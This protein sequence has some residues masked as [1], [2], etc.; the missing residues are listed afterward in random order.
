M[1]SFRIILIIA[2]FAAVASLSAADMTFLE[3][4]QKTVSPKT[5]VHAAASQYKPSDGESKALNEAMDRVRERKDI[6]AAIRT[7]AAKYPKSPNVE[8][9]AYTAIEQ[10]YYSGKKDDLEKRC[11]DYFKKYPTGLHSERVLDYYRWAKDLYLEVYSHSSFT[12]DTDASVYLNM[13]N[14]GAVTLEVHAV[15]GNAI[16]VPLR[17]IDP[18]AFPLNANTKV[19]EVTQ[20][21]KQNGPWGEKRTFYGSVTLGK[22]KP[23]LY[24]VLAKTKEMQSATIISVSRLGVISKSDMGKSVLFVMDKITGEPVRDAS[25]KAYY[26]DALVATGSSDADGIAVLAKNPKYSGSFS[27]TVRRENDIAFID[28]YHGYGQQKTYKTYFYTDRPVYR[29]AQSVNYKIILREKAEGLSYSVPAESSFKVVIETPT[30]KKVYEKAVTANEYGAIADS[31]ELAERAELGWYRFRVLDKHGSQ[32]TDQFYTYWMPETVK[33]F[34][35]EEYKKPEFKMTVSPEKPS[36]MKGDDVTMNVDVKYYFGE[37]VKKGVVEYRITYAQHSVPYWYYYP[38]AWYYSEDY[39]YD[40][41]DDRP[42]RGRGRYRRNYEEVLVEGKAE[43]DEKGI[44]RIKFTAKDIPYDAKYTVSVR[45][46]DSSRRMIEGAASVKVAQAEFAATLRSDKYVYRPNDAALITFSGK[47]I[48]GRAF[49]FAGEL[50]IERYDWNN[51]SEKR[52]KVSVQEV[53]TE[54][55]GSGVFTFVP[56]REGNYYLT[57][58]A[59]DSRGRVVSARHSVYVAGYSYQSFYNYSSLTIVPNK[60]QYDIGDTA[61]MMIQSPYPS[62]YAIVSC[63]SERLLSYKVVKMNGSVAVLDCPLTE[64][65]APNFYYTVT[66]VRQNQMNTQTKPII[67]LPRKRFLT[68]AIKPNKASYRPGET[69]MFDLTVTD[70]HKNPVACDLSF[71]LVDASLYYIQEEFAKDPREFFYGKTQLRVSTGN[72]FHVYFHGKRRSAQAALGAAA[73][74][75][76]A[77][78]EMRSESMSKSASEKSKKD[79]GDRDDAAG[80]EKEP[81]VRGYFPDTAFW[82]HSIRTG[83]DGKATIT[84]KMPDTLTAW[85]ATVRAV[86]LA[87]GVGSERGETVTF[88]NLLCRLELPRFI[89]QDDVLTI[90]GIVHNYLKSEKSV[91]AELTAAGVNMAASNSMRDKLPSGVDKRFD[92]KVIADKPGRAEFTLKALTDE[93]SDAMKLSI[94]ILAHG[95]PR[96]VISSEVLTGGGITRTVD[97]PA[98]AIR[99]TAE[100]AVNASGSIAAAMFASLD[101]LIGYPYGCVEQ[102]MSRFLPNV[103]VAQSVKRLKLP[104]PEIFKKLPD[105]MDKGLTRLY[106]LQHS[107]GG[108]GWWNNDETH[109][110]MTAYVMYGLSLTREAGYQINENAYSRG[111][112]ALMSIYQREK[113]SDIKAYMAMSMSYLKDADKKAIIDLVQSEKDL[114]T[115]GRSLL[116]MALIRIG[117][118]DKAAPLIRAIKV[119]ASETESTC[120]FPG[121][122]F[123]Y[124]WQKN[125][126]EV[127]ALAMKAITMFDHNDA[128]LPKIINWLLVRREGNYWVSTKDT[129]LVVFSFAEYLDRTGE[130][131]ADYEYTIAV[132]TKE[133]MKGRID[134]KTILQGGYSARIPAAGLVPG[135]NVITLT[136]NGGGRLYLSLALTYFNYEKEI[137]PE[138]KNITITRSHEVIAKVRD[139]KGNVVKEERR[140]LTQGVNSGDEIEVTLT[141]EAKDTLEYIMIEDY[142]PAGCEIIDRDSVNSWYSHKEFRDEKAVFFITKYY[143]HSSKKTIQY[144]LRAEI[145]GKYEILPARAESMYF[146]EVR[147]NTASSRVSILERRP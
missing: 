140:P 106:D 44:C 61:V 17:E 27:L 6:D 86:S 99:D 81:E 100:L 90:S 85:R 39:G 31:F 134:P 37:P 115:Y 34:R 64:A 109:P 102:T 2:A 25:L 12:P 82:A 91:R 76:S 47:D 92:W 128:L 78:K 93:E 88:K 20:E 131:A 9:L 16:Q 51:G 35:V 30:G 107:D 60:D 95:L 101:Y 118:R 48:E 72:S 117:E 133:I 70:G 41:D 4:P 65:Y 96:R 49:P 142:I 33:A 54:K 139:E 112:S 147:A 66:V 94:P 108:W 38:F 138:A 68:V 45:V 98:S 57:L 122:S 22:F 80:N 132:N 84:V 114:S 58:T 126:L 29:P 104:E 7:F 103:I 144:R 40:D 74:S 111:R 19:A 67:V 87:T 135:K 121:D 77:D 42:R 110:Y 136:K 36:Y 129:A 116:A 50:S 124:S 73:P 113:P 15:P 130:M 13:R 69:A 79:S 119:K 71:S 11:S 123:K 145:P 120:L 3:T 53:R 97:L 46:T 32:I 105:M 28:V 5:E 52:E 137:T 26:G 10:V 146:P 55:S 23:G 43:T 141:V 125:D 14:T 8:L 143:Y 1:R 62:G 63:E 18:Y 75:A 56:K 89:T 83:D 59:K 127:T 24:V 21:E